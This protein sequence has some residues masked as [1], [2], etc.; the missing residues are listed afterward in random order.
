MITVEAKQ[1]R[2][3]N[4]EVWPMSLKWRHAFTECVRANGGG[5]SNTAFFQEGMGAEEFIA[6]DVPARYRSHLRKGYAVRF[7]VDP[8]TV[9]HW[10]GY[11]AHTVAEN[12]L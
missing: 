6:Q 3:G 12:G 9:G 4:V 5:E 8:W 2:M 7:R 11:D 10:Y 1:D